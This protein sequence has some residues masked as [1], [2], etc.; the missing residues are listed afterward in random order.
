MII[1]LKKVRTCI[2]FESI[3]AQSRGFIKSMTT[4]EN[5]ISLEIDDKKYENLTTAQKQAV[6][7]K[8]EKMFSHMLLSV[9]SEIK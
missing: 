9:K 7:D 6:K 8:I 3:I 2:D 5:G 4:N 1:E